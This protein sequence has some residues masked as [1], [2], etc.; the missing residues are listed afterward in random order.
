MTQHRETREF[1]Y[2]FSRQGKHREFKELKK[3]GK[4][5]VIFRFQFRIKFEVGNFIVA[6]RVIEHIFAFKKKPKKQETI[7]NTG[8]SQ[9]TEGLLVIYR[10]LM[11]TNISALS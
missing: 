8:K 9:D 7:V 1:D 6:I 5:W 11:S 4:R 3:T 2:Q 10:V